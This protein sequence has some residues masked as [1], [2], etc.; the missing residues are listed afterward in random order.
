LRVGAIGLGRPWKLAA[1]TALL[2][3]LVSNVPAVLVL[4][5]FVGH[6]ATPQRAWLIIAMAATFAGNLT[7]LGS[8]ANLIVVQLARAQGVTLGFWQYFRVGAPL[9]L[10]T[11]G[12]GLCWL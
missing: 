1:V 8:V 10:L 3:N 5:P 11:I 7:V 9:T 12:L 2:S 6:L 4:K